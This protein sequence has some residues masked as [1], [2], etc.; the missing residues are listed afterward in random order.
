MTD[1]IINLQDI[2]AFLDEAKLSLF[3][4]SLPP[5]R[6]EHILAPTRLEDRARRAAAEFALKRACRELGVPYSS[7]TVTYTKN[8]K[9]YI[10]SPKG[11]A[12]SISHSALLSCVALVSS[13]E[14]VEIGVDLEVLRE[15]PRY[16][17]L[18]KRYF[19]EELLA[20]YLATP[21]EQQEETFIHLWTCFEAAAKVDGRGLGRC[22]G[23]ANFP[24][25]YRRSYTTTDVGGQRYYVTLASNKN[26]FPHTLAIEGAICYNKGVNHRKE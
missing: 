7:L 2:T 17:A 1:T 3:L 23:K 9:P 25:R 15:T 6:Q 8:G 20:I 16:D 26:I 14:E 21:P 10:P 18:A 13:S 4:S 11:L 5:Y 19:P 22:M 24:S 12:I